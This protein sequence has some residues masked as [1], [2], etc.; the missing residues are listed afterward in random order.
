MQRF[1]KQFKIG[2]KVLLEGN[3]NFST[4]VEVHETRKWIKVNDYN[5]SFQRVHVTKYTNKRA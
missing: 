3:K 2:T 1:N 4:V 5:G